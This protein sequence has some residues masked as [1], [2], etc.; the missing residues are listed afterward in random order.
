MKY[1]LMYW[2][3]FLTRM[4]EFHLALCILQ[5]MR[6]GEDMTGVPEYM[7]EAFATP[8]SYLND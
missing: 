6:L 2:H 7:R 4:G 1:E 5:G 3:A 8:S